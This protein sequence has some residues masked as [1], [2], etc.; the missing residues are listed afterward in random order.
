MYKRRFW[1]ESNNKKIRIDDNLRNY[2]YLTITLRKFNESK[3][4]ILKQYLTARSFSCSRSQTSL[5]PK[6]ILF[7]SQTFTENLDLVYTKYSLIRSLH[8]WCWKS[9]MT[10]LSISKCIFAVSSENVSV[11][12]ASNTCK[13]VIFPNCKYDRTPV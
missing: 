4:L 13:T 9:V 6:K 2:F 7:I 3:D 5:Y 1:F 11:V 8:V 12:L 10:F